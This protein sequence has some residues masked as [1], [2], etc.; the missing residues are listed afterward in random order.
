MAAF[1]MS[2]VCNCS[3]FW[4][5]TRCSHLTVLPISV[6]PYLVLPDYFLLWRHSL[7][8]RNTLP[9]RKSNRSSRD[10]SDL[11]TVVMNVRQYSLESLVLL[12]VLTQL[13][14]VWWLLLMCC[15]CFPLLFWMRPSTGGSS[16]EKKPQLF[17]SHDI[18]SCVWEHKARTGKSM[19]N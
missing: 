1:D 15:F 5:Y 18:K 3:F 13:T 9:I 11:F 10:E 2:E 6:L 16:Q 17:I 8:R 14:V 19:F 4:T 12:T 7:G